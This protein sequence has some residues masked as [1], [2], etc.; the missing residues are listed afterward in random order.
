[1]GY[2]GSGFGRTEGGMVRWCDGS[3]VRW[4][5]GAKVR[6]GEGAGKVREGTLRLRTFCAAR[7]LQSVGSRRLG[8][9]DYDNWNRTANGFEP[10]SEL[11][12]ERGEQRQPVARCGISPRWGRQREPCCRLL[13]VRTPAGC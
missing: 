5:E 1:M 7:D 13:G 3:K 11:F 8:A 6:C 9:V 12:L 2:V 4:C 10:E